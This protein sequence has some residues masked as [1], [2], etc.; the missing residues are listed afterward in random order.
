GGW[1]G[2]GGAPG[3]SGRAR[4]GRLAGA[5]PHHDVLHRLH[6]RK[7]VVGED[8]VVER[9]Q[10]DVAG[11]QQEVRVVDG[12]RHL[13]DGD[14]LRVEQVA[15]Q[16]D[17]DLTDLPAVHVGGGD[18][19]QALELRLDGVV[20]EIVELL[21]IEPAAGGRHQTDADVGQ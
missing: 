10:L 7:L 19:V 5:P 15:I 14:A 1:G 18:A 2:P 4:A 16:I 21:L 13:G 6:D 3:A 12:A 17:G 20:G 9:P 8:V 11:G